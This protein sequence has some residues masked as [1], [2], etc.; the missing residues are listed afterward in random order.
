MN[1]PKDFRARRIA[2]G[3]TVIELLVVTAVIG[4][5][6]GLLF[7][8]FAAA[9]RSARMT[10]CVSNLHQIGL[11]LQMYQSD[12]G[13]MP[14]ETFADS[15]RFPQWKSHDP[16]APY[17]RSGAIYHCPEARPGLAGNYAYRAAFSLSIPE[18]G[19]PVVSDDR[20]I[21][22]QPTS[23]LAFCPE[24]AKPGPQQ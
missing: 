18:S 4:L 9:R 24:H 6:A 19:A 5:L 12:W 11:A 10:T 20:T 16:L 8:L 7:P 13:R 2:L 22:L 1:S 17:N 21:R 14:T 23:V 3:F 15:D